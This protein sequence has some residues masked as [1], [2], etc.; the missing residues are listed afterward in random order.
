VLGVV[1]CSVL[2]ASMRSHMSFSGLGHFPVPCRIPFF[3][4]LLNSAFNR[5]IYE[6]C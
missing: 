5:W 1:P 6:R 3:L 4:I 2:V